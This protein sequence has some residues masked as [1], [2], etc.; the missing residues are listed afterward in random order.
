M[1]QKLTQEQIDVRIQDFLSRKNYQ[2]PEL[3]LIDEEDAISPK[4]KTRGSSV[5]FKQVQNT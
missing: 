5:W 2:F 4:Q 1:I 3:H